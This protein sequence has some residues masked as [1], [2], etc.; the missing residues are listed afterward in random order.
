[1]CA[2]DSSQAGN[3]KDRSYNQLYRVSIV[4]ITSCLHVFPLGRQSVPGR[5]QSNR[6]R[7]QV[8]GRLCVVTLVCCVCFARFTCVFGAYVRCVCVQELRTAVD[9][10]HRDGSLKKAVAANPEK[11]IHKVRS[12]P[13]RV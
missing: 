4:S 6:A 2:Q 5:T 1:M 7:R 12:T 3:L 8:T 11:Y 10:C 13:K 9:M